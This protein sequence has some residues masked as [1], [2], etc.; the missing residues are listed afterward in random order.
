MRKI[1]ALVA[2]FCITACVWAQKADNALQGYYEEQGNETFYKG[3]SFDGN[4]KVVGGVANGYYFTR[5]DSLVVYPDKGVFIFKIR[6]GKLIGVSDWVDKGIWVRKK[7][8][9][10][11][12]NRKDSEEAQKTATL[13]AS[14]Y[15][16]TKKWSELDAL[17]SDELLAINEDYCNK[18]LVKACINTFGIKMVQYT[19]DLL[20]DPD[21]MKAKKLK[22]H[23]ELIQL[24]Q[25]IVNLGETEGYNLL[26]SYYL[27]LGLQ[28]K[29]LEAWTEGEK[30]GDSAS[31]L[32]KSFYDLGKDMDKESENIKNNSTNNKKK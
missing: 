18:G 10:E 30:H 7:D 21:K 27:I 17:F 6:K 8:K 4:G 26:G 16:K 1:T 20:D 13:L 3:F 31:I 32:S 28:D 24:S 25:K 11:V 9:T 5:N 23:P 29:A 22:P 12:N 19:P 15:D 14:F 2:A